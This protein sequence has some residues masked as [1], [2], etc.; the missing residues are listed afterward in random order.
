MR[1]I[2]WLIRILVATMMLVQAAMLAAAAEDL[3]AWQKRMPITF[4][5]Y[6]PPGG[7]A[8]TNFPVLVILS[9]TT[10]GTGFNYAD[11]QSPPYGDLRFGAADKTTPLDFEVEKWDTNGNS[12]AWVQVPLLTDTNTRIYALW[13]K[14]GVEV[15]ACTTNGAVWTNNYIS[16]WHLGETNGNL[17]AATS[18]R[19]ALSGNAGVTRGAT[20]AAAGA[21]S[22]NGSSGCAEMANEAAL[23]PTQVTVE[24]WAKLG[25]WSSDWHMLVTKGFDG[26]CVPYN[27]SLAPNPTGSQSQ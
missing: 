16:V 9:N 6:T 10:A 12:Y 20:G 19:Y 26:A 18:N 5:G 14:S 7:G 24:A 4:S 1:T 22:F 21:C 17:V 2:K 11:F 3:S 27:L 13:R 23:N 15:P 25:T 8:L